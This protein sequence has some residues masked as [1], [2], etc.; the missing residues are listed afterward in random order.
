MSIT[1]TSDELIDGARKQIDL[2]LKA[3]SKANMEINIEKC[4]GHEEWSAEFRIK[5]AKAQATLM[6]VREAMGDR[7]YCD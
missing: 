6:E 5:L 3:V 1:T 4:W 7:R 2:A